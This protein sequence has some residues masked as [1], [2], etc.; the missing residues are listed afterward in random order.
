MLALTVVLG[1]S[2]SRGKPRLVI[3]PSG[4]RIFY[5]PDGTVMER[6]PG[7]GEATITYPDGSITTRSRDGVITTDWPD[8]K[9][10]TEQPDGTI[11]IEFPDGSIAVRTIDPSGKVTVRTTTTT[12]VSTQDPDG[13]VTVKTPDGKTVVKDP[14]GKITV[15]D[16]NG[17]DITP[18]KSDPGNN[19]N[20]ALTALAEAL[21]AL[22]ACKVS[23]IFDLVV[24]G[25]EQPI[26]LYCA[27]NGGCR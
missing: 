19:S 23:E 1:S 27:L 7:G 21:G 6:N 11:T 22:A 13:T 4:V 24:S 26:K 16:A 25:F 10:K 17:N 2:G 12:G 14:K 3:T 15:T 8:G 18:M 5:Y 9:T 20:S